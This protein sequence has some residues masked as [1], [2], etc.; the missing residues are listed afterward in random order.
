MEVLHQEEF[1]AEDE[2]SKLLAIAFEICHELTNRDVEL[3]HL[4]G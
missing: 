3:F 1:V 4:T 2:I